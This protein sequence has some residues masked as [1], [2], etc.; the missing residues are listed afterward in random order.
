MPAY[1]NAALRDQNPRWRGGTRASALS[2]DYVS[3]QG[4]VTN[5]KEDVAMRRSAR[6]NKPITR[7]KGGYWL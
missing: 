1:R 3:R 5:G 7:K 4:G 2:G 6:K